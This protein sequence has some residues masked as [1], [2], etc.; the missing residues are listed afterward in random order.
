M[1]LVHSLVLSEF[2]W[3][4]A[5]EVVEMA[6]RE[7]DATGGSLEYDVAGL[8]LGDSVGGEG[9]EEKPWVPFTLLVTTRSAQ[10]SG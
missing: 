9:L 2:E 6:S 5:I 4:V 8:M 10:V 3:L 7:G 1:P